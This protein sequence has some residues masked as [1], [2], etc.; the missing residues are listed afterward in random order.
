M[1]SADAAV[2]FFAML[3][4]MNLRFRTRQSAPFS[5]GRPPRHASS[6]PDQETAE[7]LV[8]DA[9]EAHAEE[10]ASWLAGGGRWL[11]LDATFDRPSGRSASERGVEEVSGVRVVLA[12]DAK[13]PDG[14]RVHTC[15][16]QAARSPHTPLPTLRHLVGAYFHQDWDTDYR[17]YP[18]ALDAF[19]RDSPDL[20]TPLVDELA[21]VRGLS[22]SELDAMLDLLGCQFVLLEGETWHEWLDDLTRRLITQ[23]P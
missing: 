19:L 21:K 4:V 3:P 8:A 7:K 18:R 15:Y 14:F 16:P 11:V 9:V 10:V 17:E 12:R 20:A 6:F 23:R 2:P 13:M 5:G 22:E 1:D